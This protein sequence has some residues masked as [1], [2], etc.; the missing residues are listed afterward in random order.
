MTSKELNSWVNSTVMEMNTPMMKTL[1][2]L[3]T[4]V[5]N[6]FWKERNKSGADC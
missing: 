6:C 4:R 3:N 1:T 5:R 2:A